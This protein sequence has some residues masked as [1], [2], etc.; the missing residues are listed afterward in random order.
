MPRVGSSP[1]DLS[2]T[3]MHAALQSL[4]FAPD[5]FEGVWTDVSQVHCLASSHQMKVYL[6]RAK[7]ILL[8]RGR[9]LVVD[10][11][12]VFLECLGSALRRWI[13]A[14]QGCMPL[15]CAK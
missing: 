3:R 13:S 4:T 7:W 2:G 11:P 1:M 15:Q 12:D 8:R 6:V 14:E 9:M 5:P 10:G